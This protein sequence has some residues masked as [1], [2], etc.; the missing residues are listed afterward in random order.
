VLLLHLFDR[1]NS[2]AEAS[3]LGKFLLNR[4]QP[5]LALAMSDVGLCVVVAFTPILVVQRLKLCDLGT[6]K[7][8]LVAKDFEVIHKL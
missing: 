3:E 7:S 4:L 1:E 6:E 2:S 5:L 8:N